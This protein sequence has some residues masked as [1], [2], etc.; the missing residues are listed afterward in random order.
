M[1]YVIY[2]ATHIWDVQELSVA[3]R[4]HT[5]S[6][7]GRLVR[8]EYDPDITLRSAHDAFVFLDRYLKPGPPQK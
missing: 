7:G 5:E 6:A 2:P 4:P 1:E 8:V 3:P